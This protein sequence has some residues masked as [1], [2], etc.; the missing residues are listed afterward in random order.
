MRE[1]ILRQ[2]EPLLMPR[3]FA[4][5]SVADGAEAVGGAKPTL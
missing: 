5:V 3:G 2:A 1:L 4:T